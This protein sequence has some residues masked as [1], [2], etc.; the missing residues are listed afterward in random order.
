MTPDLSKNAHVLQDGASKALG[1]PA[2]VAPTAIVL[3]QQQ[4]YKNPPTETHQGRR[5]AV[6]SFGEMFDITPALG[7]GLD[8]DDAMKI[9]NACRHPEKLDDSGPDWTSGAWQAGEDPELG[10][11]DWFNQIDEIP[12]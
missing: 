11:T 2:R 8:L 9:L 4:D 3:Q 12:F 10:T 5:L 7:L 1:E 6:L